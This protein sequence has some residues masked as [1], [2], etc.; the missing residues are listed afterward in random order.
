MD[1]ASQTENLILRSDHDGIAVLTRNSPGSVNAPSEAML[2]ALSATPDAVAAD[3]SVKMVSLRSSGSH[4]RAGHNLN[5]MTARRADDGGGYRYFQDFFARCPA[6]MLRILRLPR[7]VI[8]GVSGTVGKSPLAVKSGKRAV[9]KQ[10]ER[11]LEEAYAF[12]RHGTF[13][14]HVRQRQDLL[15]RSEKGTFFPSRNQPCR[16]PGDGGRETGANYTASLPN[17]RARRPKTNCPPT[18]KRTLPGTCV[19][20]R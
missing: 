18:P 6:M 12:A 5:E 19:P 17:S 9:C 20:G 15:C 4:L 10:P 8:A 14:R 2:A 13:R 7:P 11:P 16:S 1:A 3:H